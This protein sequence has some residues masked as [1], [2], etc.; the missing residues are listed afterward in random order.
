M[1]A[2]VRVVDLVKNYYL[3]SVTVHA[4]QGVNLD[5][6]RGRFRRPHGAV[7]VR[8]VHPAQPARLPRPA[9]QRPYFLG[10]EDV[11]EMDDD[12]LS[13]VR[14]RYLGFI[15]QSYNLLP[16]YTVVENI[17]LPLLYQGMPARRGDAG[18]VHR[19][20]RAGRP[21]RPARPPADAALRRPA[22]ARGHRPQPWSTTRT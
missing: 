1:P 22:A 11:A 10:D 3:E 16:Q 21:G 5:G 8:Q 12:Q 9:D 7:R 4:L 14:S 2:I 13:E 20:G 17:E 15:F 19:A 6:R 18:P